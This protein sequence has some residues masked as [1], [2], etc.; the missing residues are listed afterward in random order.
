[1]E[2]A[3][4]QASVGD[5]AGVEGGDAEEHDGNQSW[6]AHTVRSLVLAELD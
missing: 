5:E 6:L 3:E 1:M 2:L 4:Q